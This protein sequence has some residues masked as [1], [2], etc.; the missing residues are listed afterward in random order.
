[1]HLV[2]GL[3]AF[4]VLWAL[5]VTGTQAA[6][7]ISNSFIVQFAGDLYTAIITEQLRLE[8]LA[9]LRANSIS[10][11]VKQNY[12]EVFAGSNVDF[13]AI[14]VDFAAS[15]DSV[16]A[17]APN[18]IITHAVNPNLI[19]HQSRNF[20]TGINYAH[21]N[22]HVEQF[23][24]KYQLYGSGVKVG[25][26]DTGIDYTHP[27][28][29][30]CFNTTGC[31]VQYGYDFVGENFTGRNA[32]VP[33]KDP[34]DKCHGHGTHVAGIIAADDGTFKGV[35]YK[36]ILGVYRVI[37]CQGSTSSAVVILAL[38][39]AYE[40]GM[41]VINLSFG[42]PAGFAADIQS[43]CSD[44][45]FQKGVIVVAAAGNDGLN[46]AWLSSSP[47]MGK[48]VIS[49]GSSTNSK[50][51]MFGIRDDSTGKVIRRSVEQSR[52]VQ[53]AFSSTQLALGID[54]TGDY[55]GCYP[56]TADLTG[57]IALVYQAPCG[58]TIQARNAQAAGAVGLIVHY[59][60]D[61]P[62]IGFITMPQGLIPTVA[63]GKEGGLDW[64]TRLKANKPVSITSDLGTVWWTDGPNTP[65]PSNFSSWGPGPMLEAKPVISAPGE[66]IFST[67]PTNMG[68]FAV[69]SGTSMAAPYIA[70]CVALLIQ[71]YRS[72]ITDYVQDLI[73]SS[74][75]MKMSKYDGNGDP[76]VRSGAGFVNMDN[77]IAKFDIGVTADF[78]MG[79]LS[80]TYSDGSNT[81]RIRFLLKNRSAQRTY[82][83]SYAY[84]GT[85][86]ITGFDDQGNLL[87]QVKTKNLSYEVRSTKA[88]Q[89]RLAPGA[90]YQ[91]EITIRVTN[92]D[93]SPYW[94]Y[95]G[96]LVCTFSSQGTTSFKRKIPFV[97]YNGYLSDVPFFAP[98]SS[99]NYPTLAN[100]TNGMPLPATPIP[101]FSMVNNDNPKL[102]FRLQ[103]NSELLEVYYGFRNSSGTFTLPAQYGYNAYMRRNHPGGDSSYKFNMTCRYLLEDGV[104]TAPLPSG[105][106]FLQ[107][108]LKKPNVSPFIDEKYIFNS[109]EFN[110]QW[111]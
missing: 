18:V 94:A 104:T 58:A 17:I 91:G 49:V 3:L 8:F 45:L 85:Q 103:Y 109:T 4:G 13:T 29:G 93:I 84:Y 78:S 74:E 86:S 10:Y 43:Y 59:T 54:R 69:I 68:G 102:L 52:N 46:G 79:D 9:S 50:W 51:V 95:T 7:V 63:I 1:M 61:L 22:T 82:S 55:W 23:R 48:N 81:P 70:G 14:Y 98:I 38:Q 37:S 25:I 62:L 60:S 65:A 39:R 67:F 44:F 99:P 72:S 100:A 108:R 101:T 16:H 73:T 11:N 33:D 42:Q 5:S 15:L 89:S 41:Q 88:L 34:L 2:R 35:A 30:N 6:E 76:T 96:F 97:G 71:K 57:K 75:P 47:A 64:V 36:A 105:T 87:T 19:A 107:L 27:A 92:T 106:Y 77:I 66:Y 12:S 28:F 56:I 26:L 90:N 21:A 20:G 32:P 40:D 53:F 80:V 111:A 83:I 31:R 24:D 110:I